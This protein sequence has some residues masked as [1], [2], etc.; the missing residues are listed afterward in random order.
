MTRSERLAYLL[1]AARE[2]PTEKYKSIAHRLEFAYIAA[3]DEE[4]FIEDLFIIRGEE[5]AKAKWRGE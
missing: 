4:R 1:E 3:L 5:I 2:R